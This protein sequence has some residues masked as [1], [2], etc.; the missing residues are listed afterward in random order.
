KTAVDRTKDLLVVSISKN[1]NLNDK[2][3]RSSSFRIAD[4]GCSIGP[5]TF[6]VMD[7]IIKAVRDKYKA[8]ERTANIP[9]FFVFFNDHITNDFNALFASLPGER[10]YIAAGVPGSFH[11]RLFPKAALDFIYSSNALHWLSKAPKELSDK[12]SP[13]YNVERIFYINSPTAVC[14][15][16]LAQ[17]TKDMESF[18]S[19]RAQELISG[20]L[21]VLLFP[22]R[23]NGAGRSAYTS[24]G[25][26]FFPLEAIL[27]E[28]E[29]EGM[30]SKN[31]MEHFNVPIYYPSPDELT[32]II[33]R[34]DNFEIVQL[35]IFSEKS[36]PVVSKQILRAAMGG[37]LSSHFRIEIME[38][39][40]VRYEKNIPSLCLRNQNAPECDAVLIY[41]AL[42]CKKSW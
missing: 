25:H 12:N 42:W 22:G 35:D 24:G 3:T 10:Q 36:M 4:L 5:T 34:N 23:M 30:V 6:Y 19:A 38:E 33:Q 37:M 14:D 26:S 29:K 27:L 15:A 17:F 7:I 39:I 40:F 32:S 18:L 13:A 31:E 41:I 16:Y 8:E 1:L 28:L 9:E 21:M 11:G 2:F 20:G